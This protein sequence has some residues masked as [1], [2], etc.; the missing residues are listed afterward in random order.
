MLDQHKA[1]FK[2]GLGRVKGTTAKFYINPDIQPK[3]YKACPVPYALQPK[4]EAALKKLE[5]D[6]VIKPVQFSQRA[7]T[8]VTVLKSD[9]SVQICG[10]YKVTLNQA[11]TT[12]TY[13][14]PKIEDLFMLLSGG[15]LFSCFPRWT[16]PVLIYK[17][18]LR[19]SQGNILQSVPTRDCIVTIDFPLE[20]H[21]LLLCSNALWKIS[22]KGSVMYWF[23]LTIS[24]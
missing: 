14:L 20:S 7:D 23:T 21:L 18:P 4:V 2:E 8:I 1:A 16:W 15:K 9:G 10:D 24:W 19:K 12:D 17:F 11:A 6:G 22:Y 13:L 5:A 3:F